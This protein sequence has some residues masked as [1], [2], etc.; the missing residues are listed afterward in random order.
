MLQERSSRQGQASSLHDWDSVAVLE[1]Q[2]AFGVSSG[3][4]RADVAPAS[5]TLADHETRVVSMPF[6]VTLIGLAVLASIGVGVAAYRASLRAVKR[7]VA[8]ENLALAESLDRI[9]QGEMRSVADPDRDLERTRDRVLQYWREVE[10]PYPGMFV[11]IVDPSGKIVRHSASPDGVGREVGQVVLESGAEFTLSDL[12][13]QHGRWSG[14]NINAAGMQQLVGYYYSP[15]VEGAIAVHVPQ[16]AITA[17]YQQTMVPWLY[18]FGGV[19]GFLIPTLFGLLLWHLA[20]TRQRLRRYIAQIQAS[21]SRLRA[22]LNAG[23]EC[24]KMLDAQG[25]LVDINQAGLQMVEAEEFEQIGGQNVSRVIVPKWR[26]AFVDLNRRVFQGQTAMLRYEVVGLRGT[27]RWLETHAAPVYDSAGKVVAQLAITRD[28]SRQ[29]AAER[30]LQESEQKFRELAENAPV[31]IGII[32]DGR[33]VYAN[34]RM[35]EFTG[36]S[37]EELSRLP[38]FHNADV[39]TRR[40]VMEQVK[41]C[42]QA[43]TP[44]RLEFETHRKD[45]TSRWIDLAVRRIQFDGRPAVL[46][47]GI[48]VTDRRRAYAELDRKKQELRQLNES[49]ERSVAE[50]TH[51]LQD[52]N[53]ELE[54]FAHTVSHDLRAPLRAMEGFAV[55]L[56]EDFG[57]Q[58][59]DEGREYAQHIFAATHRMDSLINDLLSY[60]R[61]NKTSI[62]LTDVDLEDVIGSA[63]Q[64]L[65]PDIDRAQ[66]IIHL[67]AIFPVVRSNR[68]ILKQ[69]ITNLVSNALKFVAPGT[70]P[71]VTISVEELPAAARISIKDNG[72]GIPEDY[73]ETI[74]RVFERLHGIETYP[75]TGIGLAIVARGC[76]RLGCR[77]SVR[78]EP[79]S[80]STFWIEVP[81]DT[82]HVDRPRLHIAHR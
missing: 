32:Q 9:V 80:G 55:A 4:C 47:A 36:Y 31:C 22:M 60:S 37:A 6:L 64:D 51:Q 17:Y 20:S 61:L 42:L 82:P 54:S 44:T 33:R 12:L 40:L 68:R 2:C 63:L 78:S 3:N 62:H 65:A 52:S 72:I 53:A 45:G 66:A 71:E 39:E 43:G 75:G 13:Q 74:F 56:L 73:H 57:P 11:C 76:V 59:G 27:H 70:K 8:N 26:K 38:P 28:I 46:A 41:K 50:R 81:K 25:N 19:T 10:P 14:E 67:P 24:I 15:R 48:D 18:A 1:Q 7:I 34:E 21:E 69:V 5:P 23:P 49:L 16:S 35:R 29:V 30:E 58:L 77:Y 79:G